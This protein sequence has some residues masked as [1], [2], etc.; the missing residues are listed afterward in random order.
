MRIG[1]VF[2]ITTVASLWLMLNSVSAVAD[3]GLDADTS[4]TQVEVVELC[5]LARA[6]K[7]DLTFA[8]S[9]DGER[10]KDKVLSFKPIPDVVRCSYGRR[11][12]RLKGYT[13]F[14]MAPDGSAFMLE[15]SNQLFG[16]AEYFIKQ[17]GQWQFVTSEQT[18][19]F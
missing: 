5:S 9:A 4:L 19:E 14:A 17:S 10:V 11:H 16:R 8:N 13:S 7:N 15:I 18:W 2:I 1:S 6:L 3:Q 12:F